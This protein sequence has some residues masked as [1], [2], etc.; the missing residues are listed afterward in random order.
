MGEIIWILEST[1]GERFPYR[2]SI[3][4]GEEVLLCLRVQDRWPGGK[5][6]IFCKREE[7]RV[8]SPPVAEVERVPVVALKRYGKRLAVVLDRGRNKRCEFLFLKKRY[9]T[10]EGEYE[11]IFW[12][13]QQALK[14]RRPRVK[15]TAQGTSF[16]HVAIDVNE[17]YPWKFSGCK[18]TREKLPVGDYGVMG[19]EGPLAIVERKTLENLLAEFGTMSVL[20]QQLGELEVY[21][22]AALVIEANYSDFL[23]SARVKFYRSTFVA[24][25]I[26]ELFALHPKLN[27]VFA[28]SRKLAREWTL[29]FFSAIQS[30]EKDVPPAVVRE[31]VAAYSTQPSF[32]G[33]SYYGVKKKVMEEMPPQFTISLLR[34]SCPDVPQATIRKVLNDLKREGRLMS[35]GRGL[36]SYWERLDGG[37]GDP[38]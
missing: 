4:R 18:V 2:L 34:E 32:Q 38:E 33:G 1:G 16:L 30:H 12:R 11:Q 9:K 29:R 25:A 28:G 19:A 5:G 7:G 13:T 23:S 20:H 22:Y 27:I 37:E 3:K 15:L 6:N 36:K 21:R 14:E 26:A 17:K 24:K 31:A 35:H 10:K 8:W